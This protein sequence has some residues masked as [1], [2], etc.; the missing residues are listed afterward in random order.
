[1]VALRDGE[2]ASCAIADAIAEPKRVTLDSSL[3]ATAR[4]LGVSFG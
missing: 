1:M 2:I 4:A 3:V